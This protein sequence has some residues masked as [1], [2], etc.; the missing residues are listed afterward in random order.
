MPPR[1][2]VELYT[3]SDPRDGNVRY[4]G[5]A[6]NAQKRLASHLRDARR[7]KTPVYV[8][9]NELR[10]LALLPVLLV[11]ETCSAENW[12]TRERALIAEARAKGV[13]LLNVANGGNEPFCPTETRRLNGPKAAVA[14]VRT[15]EMAWIY[16]IKRKIGIDLKQGYITEAAKEKLRSAARNCPEL[17]GL[18]ANL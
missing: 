16:A 13:A 8:W 18:W 7:R 2:K 17:F 15:P 10:A 1:S 12:E 9:L 3:L 11:V 6:V 5:K 14:R 4:I